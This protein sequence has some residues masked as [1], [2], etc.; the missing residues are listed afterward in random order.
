MRNMMCRMGRLARH[1]CQNRGKFWGMAT[2]G[3]YDPNN[4][5]EIGDPAVQQEL[6]RLKGAYSTLQG[7]EVR[8]YDRR[9]T[10]IRR[11]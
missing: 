8:P 6:D 1:E 10:P 5:L 4:Y 3:G 9:S 11:P 2:L 7:R